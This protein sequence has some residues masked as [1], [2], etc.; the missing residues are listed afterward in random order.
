[1]SSL[2]AQRRIAIVTGDFVCTGGMDRANYALADF[3]SRAGHPVDLVAHRAAPELLERPRLRFHRVPKP[4][5]SYILGEP[6]LDATGRRVAREARASGGVAVVNGGNCLA[7]P[8][9]WVH[10]VHAAYPQPLAL[11]PRALLRGV[12]GRI[13]RERERKALGFARLVIANSHATRRT[14]VEELGVPGER[15]FVVYYGIDAARFAPAAASAAT[16]RRELGWEDR[17][18]LAFIGALG[19]QRKGFETLFSAWEKL[20]RGTSWD[21]N[22]V[23]I[24][25]GAE[26]ERWRHRVRVAG[27][28]GRIR[29]L[30]F[31]TDVHRLLSACDGLVA[32]T[33]YEAFGLGVAEALAMGL[34]AVVSAA[35]GVAELYP[36][37]L[38]EL[39][40]AD[41]QS[42]AEL[43]I[44]LER[45]RAAL[46]NP[47]PELKELSGRVRAR[48]WD[49]MAGQILELVERHAV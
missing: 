41:P 8:V 30:G 2:T 19:D 42:A 23:A 36:S 29:L 14:L 47:A 7:G 1:M 38:H 31:R 25:A 46:A 18:T 26:V 32:P 22:L 34:P 35:A 15:V 28:E 9:N 6:L 24:G 45:W 17:P 39:L 48:S 49:Q 12:H 40:L 4:L 20:A 33:R 10:Y 27:Q 43:A 13:A 21:V 3:A 5:S 11:R 44:A 37:G 16:I